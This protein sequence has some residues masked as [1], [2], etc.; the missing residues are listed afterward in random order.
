MEKR[1]FRDEVLR[2]TG[3]KTVADREC[4]CGT[5]TYRPHGSYGKDRDVQEVVYDLM[6]IAAYDQLKTG[7]AVYTGDWTAAEMAGKAGYLYQFM[8]NVSDE[9]EHYS[10]IAIQTK[11]FS[12]SFHPGQTFQTIAEWEG[13]M[14]LAPKKYHRFAV[15]GKELPDGVKIDKYTRCHGYK[16]RTISYAF[17]NDRIAKKFEVLGPMYEVLGSEGMKKALSVLT[18]I[19]SIEKLH[20]YGIGEVADRLLRRKLWKDYGKC[21]PLHRRIEWMKSEAKRMKENGE[22]KSERAKKMNEE[23]KSLQ[24]KIMMHGERCF[25]ASDFEHAPEVWKVVDRQ[26]VDN[27]IAYFRHVLKDY[28]APE[29]PKKN[30]HVQLKNQEK[31]CKKWQGKL[32]VYEVRGQLDYYQDKIVWYAEV[33]TTKGKYDCTTCKV[34]V[35]EPWVEPEKPK[36]PKKT[37]KKKADVKPRT[38][39]V[40]HQP[41]AEP[42]LAERLRDALLKQMKKA[43]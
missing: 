30:D 21:E 23:F 25:V 29:W 28:P 4:H 14:N 22:E 43:A 3:I 36:K 15:E 31:Q 42:T 13:V 20:G 33:H 5:L 12:C 37:S 16:P 18:A 24:Q 35:L 27:L 17:E 32:G 41:S 2:L 40:S 8:E 34:D 10:L 26:Y 6:I 7:Q 19:R 9:W 38:S 39:S 1:L 11:T